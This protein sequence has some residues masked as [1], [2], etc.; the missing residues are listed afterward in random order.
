MVAHLH[1]SVLQTLT[2]IE[3][4]PANEADVVRLARNQERELRQW[5][6]TPRR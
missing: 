5:L 1:D 4:A 6:F 2:L 3:R